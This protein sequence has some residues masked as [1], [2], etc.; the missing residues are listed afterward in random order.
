MERP[1]TSE[2]LDVELARD[3]AQREGVRLVLAGDI[4]EA[5]K[6]REKEWSNRA[7][8]RSVNTRDGWHTSIKEDDIEKYTK[9]T[10]EKD[11]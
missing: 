2:R 10:R 11:E 8:H 6:E 7:D 1:D 3:V 9:K 5:G 4:I